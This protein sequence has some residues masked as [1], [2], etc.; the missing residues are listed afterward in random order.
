MISSPQN[1]NSN[2]LGVSKLFWCFLRFTSTFWS[3]RNCVW[4]NEMSLSRR[5]YFWNIFIWF[6]EQIGFQYQIGVTTKKLWSTLKQVQSTSEA[7]PG[8]VVNF[9]RFSKDNQ[10][11][12]CYKVV[13]VA[14]QLLQNKSYQLQIN[15]CS[16]ELY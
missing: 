4:F 6:L 7:A 3:I 14:L 12:S 8:K 1:P 11:L 5:C 16:T 9:G 13:P 15:S 2:I 10:N